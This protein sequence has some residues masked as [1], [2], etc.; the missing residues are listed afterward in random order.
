MNMP[1]FTA[2]ASLHKAGGHY[3]MA[4]TPNAW[5]GSRAVLPQ[6]AQDVWTTDKV[7]EACGCTVSGFVCDCGLRPDPA[8]L[9]CIQKGGPT[10][11]V[12]ILAGL[13]M[14]H[15]TLGGIRA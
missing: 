2:E 9:A 4:G 10:R 11:V 12:Q 3:S 1:G 15:R 8:K 14:G 5:A 7:C 6:L 13:G